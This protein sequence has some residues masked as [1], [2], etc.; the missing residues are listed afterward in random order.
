M[1]V[2]RVTPKSLLLDLL[3]VTPRP[4]PVR[5]LVAVGALFELEG[6]AVRV[7]LTRLVG[8]GL[9]VSDERGSYRLAASA[10]PVSR[11]ADGWRQGERRLRP[12]TGAWLCLWHPRGGDRG[13]RTRSLRALGRFGFRE[14]RD[15]LWVR[16]DNLRAQLAALRAE[17]DQHGAAAA[18]LLFAGNELPAPVVDGW[19]D[20]LWPGRQVAARHRRARSAIERSTAGLARLAP[21]RALVESFLIGGAAIRSLARDP[22]LP[23]EIAPGAERRALTEAMRDYDRRGRAIWSRVLD[24]AALEGSPSHTSTSAQRG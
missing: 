10:D 22:L 2:D 12:W 24:S 20:S 21:S 8:R 18:A 9:L 3:R 19:I 4:V 15:G 23:D 14:G 16:P 7:A 13:E 5:H 11:W 17:L 6:N 1:P